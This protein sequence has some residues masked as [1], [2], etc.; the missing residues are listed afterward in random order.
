VWQKLNDQFDAAGID[1]ITIGIDVDA[2][3]CLPYMGPFADA[4]HPMQSFVDTTH[5]SVGAL[6][7]K[8]VPMSMWVN[9]DGTVAM[10]AHH[11]PVTPGWG[12]RPVPEGLPPRIEG[13]LAELKKAV[14]RHPQY[15]VALNAWASTGALPAA[16]PE[17][18]TEHEAK[19]VAAFELGDHFRLAGDDDQQVTYW[20]LAHTLDPNNWAAKR[21]AWSLVTTP[22]GAAPDLIQE[23]TGPYEGN[24]L[25]D[26]VAVG[27]IDRYYPPTSW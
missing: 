21:Q 15:M 3:K 9:A 27:G 8:N 20:R 4:T 23:D 22:D 6:G 26:V 2:S 24:W 25:D 10:D 18:M 14:D 19:A 11:S 7:F 12:D 1:V 5:A 16:D 17:T 13:R